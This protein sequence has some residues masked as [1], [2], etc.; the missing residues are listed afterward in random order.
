MDVEK[1]K[2]AAIEIDKHKTALK[3]LD[4]YGPQY[5]GRDKGEASV[6]I[7]LHLASACDGAKEAQEMISS[8][9]RLS[10]VGLI[11]TATQNC[12]NTIE[13]YENVIREE[14]ARQ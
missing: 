2:R 9:A 11:Q 10:I 12:R 5:T 14:A 8:Y 1:I 7:R 4:E 6:D 13:I 3:W